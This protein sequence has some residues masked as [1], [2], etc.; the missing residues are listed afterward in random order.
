MIII[1]IHTNKSLI[2]IIHFYY[3]VLTD[4]QSMQSTNSFNQVCYITNSIVCTGNFLFN[5]TAKWKWKYVFIYNSESL[6]F[7]IENCLQIRF[8]HTAL[9]WLLFATIYTFSNIQFHFGRREFVVLYKVSLLFACGSVL[10]YTFVTHIETV[11]FNNL[12]LIIFLIYRK[13]DL[14]Y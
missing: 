10:Y 7:H 9:K 2:Y 12:K 5:F 13:Y 11:W 6:I 3:W 4:W 8:D 1:S 14:M